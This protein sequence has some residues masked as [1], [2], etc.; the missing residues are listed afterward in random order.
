[1]IICIIDVAVANYR[2]AQNRWEYYHSAFNQREREREMERSGGSLRNIIILFW[3]YDINTVSSV[4]S[5]RQRETNQCAMKM[6]LDE[7]SFI[8]LQSQNNSVSMQL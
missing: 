1:M 2:P 3:N 5:C 8:K 7:L 6:S 4:L